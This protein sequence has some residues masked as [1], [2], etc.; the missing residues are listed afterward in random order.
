MASTSNIIQAMNNVTLDD[1]EEEGLA[2]EVETGEQCLDTNQEFNAELCLVDRFLVEGIVDFSAM[3]Q[4]LA[5]IWRPGKGV[6]IKEIDIN[7]YL[8]QFYHEL[9]IKR[10]IDGSPRSFNRKSLVIA[11]MKTWDIPRAIKLNSIDLW[12]QIHEL[13]AG[14]MTEKV[15]KEVGNYIGSFVES[16]PSNFRGV[17]REYLRVRVTIDLSK[18]LKRRM[19]VR[20]TGNDWF[21]IVF[22][23][24]NAPTFC[25]ICGLM[26][27]LGEIL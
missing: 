20:K 9:D 21:W 2:F 19:K 6:F 16:C 13:R 17:W 24:E 22:K 25:F 3:K 7:L 26:G 4:T 15:V 23:Y 11:R 18:S 1:E 10:V 8:F 5:A 12:V 27:A 14:F